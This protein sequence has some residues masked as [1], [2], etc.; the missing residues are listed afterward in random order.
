MSLLTGLPP[1][2]EDIEINVL[3]LSSSNRSESVR[4]H[5]NQLQT[6]L[7]SGRGGFGQVAPGRQ[8]VRGQDAESQSSKPGRRRWYRRGRE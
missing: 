8:L 3:T 5:F 7:R 1:H 6:P 2:Q 4:T